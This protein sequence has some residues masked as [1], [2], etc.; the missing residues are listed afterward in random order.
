ME[1]LMEIQM[2]KPSVGPRKILRAPALRRGREIIPISNRVKL[3]KVLGLTVTNN[4]A[5][6]CDPNSGI[7]AYPAGCVVVVYNVRKNKQGHILSSSKK[8]ITSLAFS[9]DGK[10]LATGECGHQPHVRVWDVQEKIQVAEFQGHKYGINCV[11]FSP[12]L[13]YVVSVGSQH[14][15]IVN[16]WEWKNNV[17]V[18]SNKVSCKVKALSFASNGN[19]FVTVGNRHVKFWYLEY[20]RS[21]KYKHEPV[22]LMGR[23]AILGDQRNNYFCDV[24]CGKGEMAES[25]Y[26][27]TKSGLLCEFN[28]RRLLDKWV[29]LRTTS[30]N[31]IS[32]SENLII[33]G[34]A[35]GIIRCFS[36][37][38]LN[39]IS[40]LPRPHVLGV[41]VA[42]GLVGS[43]AAT[44]HLS[45][46]KYP[47]TIAIA[48]D[49]IHK[50]VACVYNDH[51]FYVWDIKDVKK[52]GKSHSYLYHSACIWGIE[53]YPE[54]HESSKNILP[55][56]TFLTCS[57]DDTIR[58]WNL[59]SSM[60]EDTAY[61]RNIYSSELLKIL[62]VDKELS[63]LCDTDL[64]SSGSNDKV[65]TTYDGKNGVRCL[66]I[67]PDGRSLASGDRSGNIRIHDLE[68]VEELCKIEAHD[69]E[70]LCLEYSKPIT[71]AGQEKRY[72]ASASRDRLIHVFDVKQDHSFQQ[73][74]D[75]HSSS[76]TAVRFVQNEGSLQMISCG[77]DKSIIFRK[78]TFNPELSLA[79][80]HHVVGKTTL[81]DMEVDPQQKHILTACQD[82]NIRV[83][84]VT[85]G[86]HVR[87][88]RGSQGED[89]TLIKV[90][91]DPSGTY[92]A[93]SCTDKS[94]YLYDYIS[95][96][97]LA[98][99]F[100]HSELVTGLKFTNDGRHLISVSGDGCIFMWKLPIDVTQTMVNKQLLIE[101]PGLPSLWQDTRKTAIAVTKPLQLLEN[102]EEDKAE[103]DLNLANH[104]NGD[105]ETTPE[106]YRF[107]IGQ[108]PL[109][110]KKQ[111]L[112]KLPEGINNQNLPPP[113]P[114]RG[115]WAQRI[116]GQGL[117]VRSYLDSDS[118][119]PFP[120]P[121]DE[122]EMSVAKRE[123]QV[124]EHSE[125]SSMSINE[126][127]DNFEVSGQSLREILNGTSY[128]EE[129]SG[130]ISSRQTF[131]SLQSSSNRRSK[132]RSLANSNNTRLEDLDAEDER[133]DSE[134]SEMVY[135]PAS[136]DGS[137]NADVSF[138]VCANN[139]ND[140]KD[141]TN[142]LKKSKLE[143]VPTIN[144]P[145]HETN[146][147][148]EDPSTPVDSDRSFLSSLCISTENLE[149]LGQREKFM[150]SNYE[151]LEKSD[152]IESQHS[153]NEMVDRSFY[154]QSISAKFL[155]GSLV[156]L[157]RSL[158][159]GSS[160]PTGILE[161]QMSTPTKKREELLKALSD[162]KKTLETVRHR[163]GL[164]SSKS[165]ADLHSTPD[166]E[167]FKSPRYKSPG[168]IRKAASMTDLS[169]NN[170]NRSAF[171]P[172]PKNEPEATAPLWSQ[173]KIYPIETSP[174][175]SPKLN[176]SSSMVLNHITQKGQASQPE[177]VSR[178][179]SSS[180][181]YNKSQNSSSS[182]YK[183][184]SS[185]AL[186]RT[187][188]HRSGFN[189]NLSL[190]R[191]T[192][193]PGGRSNLPS[194]PP[195]NHTP[196]I[197]TAALATDS[198]SDSSPSESTPVKS[199]RPM[200]SPRPLG[201]RQRY[202]SLSENVDPLDIKTS[203]E[204]SSE[205]LQKLRLKSHSE[206]DLKNSSMDESIKSKGSWQSSRY[207]SY[208]PRKSHIRPLKLN[209][210]GGGSAMH[211]TPLNSQN[212]EDRKDF[213]YS[214]QI[215]FLSWD[216]TSVPLTPDLCDNIA[217]GLARVSSF[218]TQVYQRLT[219]STD[220]PP[221]E[222]SVM[223]NT[224]AQGVWQAQQILRPAVPP[225]QPWSSSSEHSIDS[226]RLPGLNFPYSNGNLNDP[227]LQRLPTHCLSHPEG[228]NAM[229]LLEQYSNKLVS[230]VEQKMSNSQD[231]PNN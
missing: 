13:K 1:T 47:D 208:S 18:A 225:S 112:E 197:T 177:Q 151:S 28:S 67:S 107:S 227:S 186:D 66:R 117:V 70:V 9:S 73:T 98:T 162:A 7:V 104:N 223:T 55:K 192:P 182:L 226:R 44:S 110:A 196:T 30:A 69:S 140:T 149:R 168:D 204:N 131:N 142:H 34:C 212:S 152:S 122:S 143:R 62:Y 129:I 175:D 144:T 21:A 46:A 3:E 33:I 125:Y 205:G 157:K 171:S 132:I 37:F 202:S 228:M 164:S 160:K 185:Y 57:S 213:G 127:K 113:I 134:V 190:L 40:T 172:P 136:E 81:Y 145:E 26:A 48:L 95:G 41:N 133:S 200:I 119:I 68:F 78:A 231:K 215:S 198:S 169:I 123:S 92:L 106:G 218:A 161:R 51:S 29:E 87:C 93:T 5:F 85:N 217:D 100:G 52:V 167:I 54:V 135:Y 137:D 99:M 207:L 165:I 89:G 94:L 59:E 203:L 128:T 2:D 24:A 60:D 102:N 166:R 159:N 148:E 187:S 42:N 45:N 14:D 181:L 97:C 15:M 96:E 155:S 38:N 180:S 74:L 114:P 84:S 49:E 10:Y 76:I 210:S 75:D 25:T 32:V 90:V 64:N 103:D 86:K 101:R 221:D 147:D 230:L 121:G 17:K 153:N 35:E 211:S 65:D 173:T 11:A 12:N 193:S 178:S 83:Y 91:L 216:P 79:R 176:T 111:M 156:P 229:A 72:L 222:K 220:L 115:R 130:S 105:V 118:V 19:Y 124:L 191:N 53:V 39:F 8:T 23:S 209:H 201:L 219:L 63:Y 4:A 20:S 199:N 16:V 71:V 22:P 27:I 150:K 43:K 6:D 88:F 154:R 139:E 163:S 138:R 116:D 206:W 170:P 189:A 174:P 36:P 77:A 195:K 61:H 194:L 120:N 179:N 50:K 224:L 183:T 184:A 109:W 188:P 108:L 56:G 82:R 214:D 58:F 126:T 158:L 146:S 80:E 141:T 31:S